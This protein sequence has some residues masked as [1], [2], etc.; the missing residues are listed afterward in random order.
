LAEGLLYAAFDG[1]PRRA[2]IAQFGYS[3]GFIIVILS[4]LQLFTEN[5]ISV[6]LP[7]LAEWSIAKLWCM[8]RLWSV[9]LTA[10]LVGTFATAYI[11][12]TLITTRPENIAAMLE[13]SRSAAEIQDWR[14]LLLGV[15]AGFYIAALV[16]LLPSSKGFEIFTIILISWLIAAGG[17]THVIV[18][19]SKLFLVML[20][21]DIA[22]SA[23]LLHN[24]LP[25]FVGN[26]I[27]GSGL[28]ALLAYAQVSREM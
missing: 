18:G 2:F 9:V 10:N 13:L 28:F 3:A 23:V 5:T 1:H 7:L 21:G 11:T 24:L 12:L 25:V 27:G 17:F 16:W 15:P 6:I 22:V 26:V 14:A 4:R 8:I 20:N 19:S